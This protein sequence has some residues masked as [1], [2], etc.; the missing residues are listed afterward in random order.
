M[1]CRFHDCD[2]EAEVGHPTCIYHYRSG[3]FTWKKDRDYLARNLASTEATAKARLD[4]ED[5]E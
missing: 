5:E 1:R 4:S 3:L 2:R